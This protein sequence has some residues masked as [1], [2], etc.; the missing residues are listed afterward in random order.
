MSENHSI[1]PS[2]NDVKEWREIIRNNISYDCLCTDLDYHDLQEVNELVEIM[3]E[4]IAIP[5]D[6]FYM[7][8]MK[9]PYEYVKDR[10]LMID[11]FAIKNL[12][13]FLKDNKSNVKNMKAY[14]LMC[15]INITMTQTNAIASKVRH[16]MAQG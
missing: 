14:L 8:N 3:V 13:L 12:R 6:Y 5:R 4:A 9:Y 1:N 7:G 10:L 16:D 11:M 2:G 15:L